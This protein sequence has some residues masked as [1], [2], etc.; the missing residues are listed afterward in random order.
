MANFNSTCEEFFR[1]DECLHILLVIFD[2]FLLENQDLIKQY[3]LRGKHK[4]S[5]SLINWKIIRN[6]LYML[7]VFKQSKPNMNFISDD[8]IGSD[9]SS[10]F[11]FFIHL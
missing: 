6:N 9:I 5:R 1:A 2:N 4:S 7:V 10:I 8:F 3:F 11:R